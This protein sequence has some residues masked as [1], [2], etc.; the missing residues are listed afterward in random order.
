MSSRRVRRRVQSSASKLWLLQ[1]HMA[2]AFGRNIDHHRMETAVKPEKNGLQ[3]PFATPDRWDPDASRSTAPREFHRRPLQI[4]QR[5]P[6]GFPLWQQ[7][8]TA[9]GPSPRVTDAERSERVENEPGARRHPSGVANDRSFG[10]TPE[11]PKG[12]Y[13]ELCNVAVSRVQVSVPPDKRVAKRE[14]PTATTQNATSQL[15][16]NSPATARNCTVIAHFLR[17]KPSCHEPQISS[18]LTTAAFS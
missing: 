16:G 7:V 3:A 15:R 1:T 4:I 6:I 14:V 9:T 8:S 2:Q 18:G 17:T 5:L 11:L 13:P 10:P 12:I